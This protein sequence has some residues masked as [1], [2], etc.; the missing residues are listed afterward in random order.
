MRRSDRNKRVAGGWA[1]PPFIV[2]AGQHHLANWY[3][4]SIL[5]TDWA[6]ATTQNGWTDNE[7][8]AVGNSSGSDPHIRI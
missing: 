8:K 1:T 2:V 6:N 4:E 7:A 5:Q 3:R